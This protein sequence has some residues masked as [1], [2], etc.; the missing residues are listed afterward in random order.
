MIKIKEFAPLFT[1]KNEQN[2]DVS[3][4]SFRGQKVILYFY[5]KDFTG[6]C[7]IQA[8]CFNKQHD[9]FTSLG[10]KVLGVSIDGVT[11][12]RQFAI[13]LNLGFTLLSD[14]T[15]EVIKRYGLWFEKEYDGSLLTG[16]RRSTFIINEEGIITDI[17]SDVDPNTSTD[18]LLAY[19]TNKKE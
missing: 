5:P 17:F 16:A 10:Y 4:L 7:I 18:E 1:L 6:G 19:L 2:E 14:P 12:H 9:K 13:S 3:L 11:S 15:G 8:E